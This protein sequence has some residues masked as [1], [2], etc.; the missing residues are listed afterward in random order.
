[1]MSKAQP[2]PAQLKYLRNAQ[3]VCDA[4]TGG[5]GFML[6]GPGRRLTGCICYERGW[7]KYGF[8]VSVY[9]IITPAGRA[10]LAQA[11]DVEG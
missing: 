8:G 3:L 7:I 11:Q 4:G 9:W 10:V 5:N 1:M 2:T 6:Q